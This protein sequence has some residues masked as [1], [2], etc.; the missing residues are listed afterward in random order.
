MPQI[1]RP[2]AVLL[3]F[4]GTIVQEDDVP[5][6]EICAKIAQAARRTTTVSEVGRYWG[7]A[8]AQLCADSFGPAFQSQKRIEQLSLAQV[9]DHFGINLDGEALS[10][11]LYRYWA[12][13]TIFPESKRVLD[14][15]DVPLCLVSNI[16]Y[17]ELQSAL[18]HNGLH[19]DRVVTSEG[20]RAYKP[21]PEMF[22][23]A[24]ALLG[25]PPD[26]V[27]HVGDSLGSDVRGAKA[28][29]IPVLWINRKGRPVP[30]GELEPD[31]VAAD[32]TGLLDVL[33]RV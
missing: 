23:R 12:G 25:V 15:C 19:F 21:R 1:A 13:P 5:I 16:D 17:A 22:E 30:G 33:E 3:D 4:Y 8:F 14:Q 9:L 10:Q 2:R 18:R 20:C 31:Y 29:G 26:Q 27:I 11:V 24:L 32:L 7:R 28:M 6:A